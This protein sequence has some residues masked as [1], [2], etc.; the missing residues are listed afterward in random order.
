M[1]RKENYKQDVWATLRL[2]WKYILLA[3]EYDHSSVYATI[4]CIC[5]WDL[6]LTS[7]HVCWLFESRVVFLGDAFRLVPLVPPTKIKK[8]KFLCSTNSLDKWVREKLEGGSVLLMY[9]G[10]RRGDGFPSGTHQPK[11]HTMPESFSKKKNKA[12]TWNQLSCRLLVH[13]PCCFK[14]RD[15][16]YST[17]QTITSGVTSI[18][19]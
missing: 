19:L 5:V 14:V 13:Y 18:C 9:V 3:G 11:K 8:S 15:Q 6:Y 7:S 1:S 12:T 10:V 2:R 4:V 16:P 17:C